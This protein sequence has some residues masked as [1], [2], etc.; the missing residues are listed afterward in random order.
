MKAGLDPYSDPRQCSFTVGKPTVD[1]CGKANKEPSS[2][3]SPVHCKPGARQVTLPEERTLTYCS[4]QQSTSSSRPV[5]A[6]TSD[7]CSRRALCRGSRSRPPSPHYSPERLP[8]PAQSSKPVQ[9]E[10]V[11]SPEPVQAELAQS[12]TKVIPT[13]AEKIAA[14]RKP[15]KVFK[16]RKY[17][18]KRCLEEDHDE[19]EKELHKISHCDLGKFCGEDILDLEQ[20]VKALEKTHGA[21]PVQR[22]DMRELDEKVLDRVSRWF[23]VNRRELGENREMLNF[24]Y[25]N[26]TF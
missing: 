10:L 24:K 2:A 18:D 17:Y 14:T 11:R 23:G 22:K 13:M 4:P 21:T 25:S 7:A 5:R 19:I 6:P 9:R 3:I 8:K 12:P 26:W 20:L 1:D 16:K 15:S